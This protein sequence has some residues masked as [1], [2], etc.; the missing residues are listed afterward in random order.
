M[1]MSS[2]FIPEATQA[3]SEADHRA[4][5]RIASALRP[6]CHVLFI[7]DAGISAD[8]DCR[9]TEASGVSTATTVAPATASRSR[10]SS[11][12]G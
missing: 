7:T 8:S 11:L 6:D 1:N 4:I 10:R 5:D 9:P 2:S 3:L 12:A